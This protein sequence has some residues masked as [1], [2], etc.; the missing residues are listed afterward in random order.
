MKSAL[1]IEDYERVVFFYLLSQYT[2]RE[3]PFKIFE[4]DRKLL[5]LL[6]ANSRFDDIIND[7]LFNLP[8]Q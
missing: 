6:R 3:T 2:F 7:G 5:T 4:K 1:K 8:K